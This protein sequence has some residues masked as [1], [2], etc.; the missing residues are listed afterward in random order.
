MAEFERCHPSR[1]AFD[2]D[3]DGK[4]SP[5]EAKAAREARQAEMLKQFDKD[6]DGKLSKDELPERM[7]SMLEI[8][9]AS[10]RKECVSTCRSRWS[11]YH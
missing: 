5:E 2:A 3:G 10:C 8:G 1:C 4:L 11:P 6:G 7:A 9:R